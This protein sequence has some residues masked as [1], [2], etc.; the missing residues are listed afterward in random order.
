MRDALA[1]GALLVAAAAPALPGPAAPA[2]LAAALALWLALRPPR[3]E[4]AVVVAGGLV[5]LGAL[6]FAWLALTPP[7]LTDPDW[8]DATRRGYAATWDALES[9]AAV[10]EDA[11]YRRGLAG[12]VTSEEDR[13]AAF[14][15]LEEAVTVVE[16][17][18]QA[19]MLVD[20]DGEPVA[21]AGDGLL[22]EL[23]PE[24]I[25]TS[26]RAFEVSFSAVT[27]ITVE[28]LEDSRRPW[29]V[30]AARSFSTDTLPFA[31]GGRG[32]AA[33]AAASGLRW[34]L[35]PDR[36][37]AAES[38]TVLEVE[39]APFL[40]LE[41]DT[42][43]PA[44]EGGVGDR[45]STPRGIAWLVL[46]LVL[47]VLAAMGG[48][49]LALADFP[50]TG[51]RSGRTGGAARVA[52][53]A[54]A[55]SV[56]VGRAAGASPEA[57]LAA[58]AGLTLAAV[59]L[60][61]APLLPAR[62]GRL[63]RLLTAGGGAVAVLLLAATA[64]Y[65]A[66]PTSRFATDAEA[67][68]ILVLRLALTAA[69]VG[70]LALAAGRPRQG[71]SGE[72]AAASP[73]S[74]R[75]GFIQK[76]SGEPWAWVSLPLLFGG[77][78]L[79][80]HPVAALPLFIAAGATV[81]L[82]RSRARRS[83]AA[84]S[85]LLILSAVLASGIWVTASRHLLRQD[86]AQQALPRLGGL[87][88]AERLE[89]SRRVDGFFAGTDLN[90]FVPRSPRDMEGEDLAFLLW[91]ASPLA[92]TH[93][94]SRLRVSPILES[95]PSEFSFGIPVAEDGRVSLDPT[96]WRDR[97]DVPLEGRLLQGSTRVSYR[98]QPW[99]EVA[100]EMV[101]LPGYGYSPGGWLTPAAAGEVPGEVENVEAALLRGL[102]GGT[103]AS[104]LPEDSVF[105]RYAP[106]G[107]ALSSPWAEDPPL[108]PRLA[109]I[110]EGAAE[111]R[112]TAD[113]RNGT[114]PA[115]VT[116]AVDVPTGRAWAMARPVPGSST[117]AGT[118]E[119]VLEVLYLPMLAPSD[120]LER[121]GSRAL[122]VLALVFMAALLAVLVA[123][124]RAAFRGLLW[125][126]WRSYSRR[127]LVVYTALLLVPLMLLNVFLVTA[128]ENRL[129]QEQRAAGEAAL[130]TA[131]MM[132]AEYLE[133]VEPGF[134]L[135]NVL[136]DELLRWISEVVRHEVNLYWGSEQWASSKPE[137]FTARLLPRRI[138]GESY[139]GMAFLDRDLAARTNRVGEIS[140]LELYAPLRLGGE[141]VL[142]SIFF[143]MPLLAQQEEVAR[144]LATLRRQALLVTAV[145]I[146]LVTAVGVRLSRSFSRPLNELV[147]GTRRIAAGAPSLDL[148][149]SELEL[150]AL[151]EAVDEMARK[152]ALGRERLV[153]EKAVVDRMVQHITS[154]IVSV[155]PEGRVLMRN[156]VAQ[157]LLG[158]A[159]GDHLADAFAAHPRLASLT[160]W[161][162]TAGRQI[163][164]RTVRLPPTAEDTE[165]LGDDGEGGEEREWT[166]VWVP[167]P[168]DGEPAALL[169]VEDV[170]ETLRSQR[171]EAWAEMARIIAHEI[172]NP[173]TP[174][175]LNIEHVQQVWRDQQRRL[176]A[177]EGLDERFS[178]VLE[179]CA[180]NVLTQVDELRQIASEFST[181]SRIPKI[182]PRPGD[183][184]EAMGA[185]AEPY[186]T[187]PPPGIEVA[188]EVGTEA[189]G[190]LEARFDRRL[191]S[192]AV[193]NLVEN[194][195]RASA[196]GGRVVLR[197]ELRDVEAP[198]E[199]GE[200]GEGPGAG[201]EGTRPGLRQ[202][203]IAVLDSGSG[204]DPALLQRIFDPYFSTYDTGTGLGLP[205]A[206]RIAEEHGGSIAARN[207]PGGG[208]EVAITLP[209]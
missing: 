72:D 75:P 166:L 28:P 119:A 34:S 108:P 205:I 135:A 120:A 115:A 128:V 206:R 51:Q 94:L 179:R 198:G 102:R 76:L 103:A 131:E 13:L 173:L 15:T 159:V 129:R 138:P 52:L 93:A 39:D 164:Q 59:G 150:A 64:L 144:E 82:W 35:V 105:L 20:R 136:D 100:W 196:G 25:P 56:A 40:V 81:A 116:V 155:D 84:L 31:P 162:D 101:P 172:K 113:S 18:R 174:I 71:A 121:V 22:H 45:P 110:L 19:L 142:P 185:L 152:I 24:Q 58:A 178:G 127:L 107:R 154:G 98:G 89:L 183:L 26:G 95:R 109:P 61:A 67:P 145:L 90:R 117:G 11:L 47:L 186:V 114:D 191:L 199:S 180:G 65:L 194:A 32:A 96:R 140:Y 2:T 57:L 46:G 77:A 167:V 148:A 151:V 1:T 122:E 112:L 123:L 53:L 74:R 44:G 50:E 149:P 207:R 182:E 80:D 9:Q 27:L 48:T 192:R 62:R 132:V 177:G 146:I 104:G 73:D 91:Q 54:V 69:A 111:G 86:L 133:T 203:R 33:P 88:A 201:G 188:F 204:I 6:L 141:D 139:A 55:G 153:R 83:G 156:R 29:R 200:S 124:P 4:L 134:D 158:V 78:A 168:G 16:G 197:L 66:V 176:A 5:A 99:A 163:V 30:L 126:T 202:A 12:A 190:G 193:R 43:T 208:L 160:D 137:L 195:L 189:A 106:G 42:L 171:L 170:T 165:V 60:A 147:E 85:L 68:S 21:W 87:E 63:G 17:G 38:A 161:L 184:V 14:S 169:V 175:R 187:A 41:K 157:E 79:A 181:Y 97:L 7:D 70:L 92:R 36:S 10:T 143:S 130:A 125:R 209:V 118:R 8:R 37:L 3:R 23:R 49:G